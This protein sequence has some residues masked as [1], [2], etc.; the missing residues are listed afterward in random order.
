MS[1]TVSVVAGTG[2][3]GYSGDGAPAIQARLNNP[4]DLAFSPD[5]GLVFSDT[6]NHV[7]RRID[8]VT[9]VI[10][11]IAGTGE[12][13]FS[14]DGGMATGARL[15]EPYGVVVDRAGRVF[16]ADRLNGRVRV[17]GAD[18]VISTL[19]GDGSGVSSG[20]GGLATRAGLVEPNGLALSS[21]G[22]A[23]FI[24][25]VAGHRVRVFWG[26][27][28]CKGC[29]V[30][31]AEGDGCRSGGERLRGG[32]GEQRDPYDRCWDVDRYDCRGGVGS[33]AW[34]GGR[35]GRVSAGGG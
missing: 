3:A 28:R 24:A 16:F 10:S 11:T 23:L 8:A 18:G 21:D 1:W 13:G 27:G 4:F 26:W 33:A 32:Y 34:R 17:V 22:S 7:L 6:F 29:G 35:G 31:S 15:N 20:D 14:G 9:G 2:E 5:G 30:R 25:D 12:K 19:A